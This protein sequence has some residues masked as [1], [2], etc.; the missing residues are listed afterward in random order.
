LAEYYN[1]PLHQVIAFGDQHN[2]IEMLQTV[3]FGVAMNN[4]APALKVVADFITGDV[5][6]DGFSFAIEMFVL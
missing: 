2:D 3:W 5:R 6:E 1:I 4:A